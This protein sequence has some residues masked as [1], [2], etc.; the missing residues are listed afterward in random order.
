MPA[1]VD[2][3]WRF[4][5][6]EVLPMFELLF[7]AAAVA[8]IANLLLDVWVEIKRKRKNGRGGKKKSQ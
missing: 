2:R 5:E 1:K 8:T 3:G 6:K 7:A 4:C